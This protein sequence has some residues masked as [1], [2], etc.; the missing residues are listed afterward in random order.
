MNPYNL[1]VYNTFG[2]VFI[3]HYS[4]SNSNITA[5][6]QHFCNTFTALLQHVYSTFTT[7]LQHLYSTFTALLQRAFTAL[8]QDCYNT[9]SGPNTLIFKPSELLGRP[10]DKLAD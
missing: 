1:G 4:Y 8:L 5:L 6:L 10:Q 3:Q 7:L 2:G 9:F